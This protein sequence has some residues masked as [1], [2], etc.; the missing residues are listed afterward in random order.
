MTSAS[1]K[2]E[3]A[4][5][6]RT[7]RHRIPQYRIRLVALSLYTYKTNKQRNKLRGLYK[8]WGFHGGDYEEWCLLGCYAVWLL[9]EPTFRRNLAPPSS[10]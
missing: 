8:I 6:G 3:N 4:G 2:V 10:G 5:M 9:Y 7:A 1:L